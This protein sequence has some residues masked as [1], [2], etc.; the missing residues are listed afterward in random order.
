M[1]RRCAALRSGLHARR[2]S[3]PTTISTR[4]RRTSRSTPCPA[5][6]T[7]RATPTARCRAISRCRTR[8]SAC[9]SGPWDHGARVNSSPWRA[10]RAG[11]PA[12]GRGAALLRPASRRPRHRPGCRGRRSI[13][14]PSMPRN[15]A[16]P[17]A[18]RRS[19]R[20]PPL[21][22]R[23]GPPAVGRAAQR[24]RRRTRSRPTSRPAAARRRATSASP[25]STPPTTTTT[26]SER[27]AKLA[28]LHH[29]AARRAAGDRGP[30]RR[31]AV[32][33]LERA[34]RGALRLSLRGRG[35]RHACATSPRACCARIHRAEAPAPR[36]LSHDLAVAQLRRARTPRR[37]RSASRSS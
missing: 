6:P 14:S 32:A 24:R 35:R 36:E 9:C 12:A 27:E 18:G 31:V 8:T 7:A 10:R 3:A 26:G 13:T 15:G 22:H 33:R 1:P 17:R 5:G 37:C 20:Q 25:A 19:T 28:E 2:R 23:A 11:V 30:C 29:G 34:G 21:L 4:S 16:R